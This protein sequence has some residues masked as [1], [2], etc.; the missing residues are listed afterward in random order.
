MLSNQEIIKTSFARGDFRG[1]LRDLTGFFSVSLYTLSF[2]IKK[3]WVNWIPVDD[4]KPQIFKYYS[5]HL[6][7]TLKTI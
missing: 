2:V 6:I 1:L 3:V 7:F 4:W 5:K